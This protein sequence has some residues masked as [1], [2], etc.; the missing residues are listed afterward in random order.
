M[1]STSP[2]TRPG[3][4]HSLRG[5]HP[6]ARVG[7]R[8]SIL[9]AHGDDEYRREVSEYFRMMGI[10]FATTS[11]ADQTHRLARHLDASVI[12]IDTELPDE[13]G[14]LACAKLKTQYPE[15]KVLL[16]VAAETPTTQRYAAF[17][18]ADGVLYRDHDLANL[19]ETIVTASEL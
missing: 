10:R 11:T 8:P 19:L 15:S 6:Q 2:L 5:P 12:V 9:F 7:L 17:A 16:L 14:Y 13:S 4:R 1:Q 18:G 3:T